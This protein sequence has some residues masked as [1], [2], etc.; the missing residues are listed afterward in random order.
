[1][2]RG[3]RKSRY[4]ATIDACETL[5]KLPPA[6][7]GDF[8][9]IL[10]SLNP[11][12]HQIYDYR[13]SRITAQL[14]LSLFPFNSLRIA[15][16]PRTFTIEHAKRTNATIMVPFHLA[17]HIIVPFSC[18]FRDESISASFLH[19]TSGSTIRKCNVPL[20]GDACW[21]GKPPP[22]DTLCRNDA[23]LSSGS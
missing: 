20:T 22:P 14:G 23:R 7:P 12:V 5:C 3:Y 15:L 4:R 10:R 21:F 1:M 19:V 11:K 2:D 9:K 6:T 17:W 13:E 8:P 18:L 16:V